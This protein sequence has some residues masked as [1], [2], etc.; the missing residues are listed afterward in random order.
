MKRHN[1]FTL[2]ELI[3]V[4]AI[5][6]I[7]VGIAIPRFM[8]ANMSARG[9]K[10]LADMNACESAINIYYIK[11]G[12]FPD[13]IGVLVS[14]FMVVWPKPPVGK[15]I[16][17]KHDNNELKLDVQAS[18]YVYA[19]PTTGELSIKVG[20]VTLGGMTIEEILSTS[21]SSLTLTDG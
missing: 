7:L 18:K 1:G 21:E 12:A 11:T 6:A 9:S 17:K 4:I 15:A 2:I 8:N 19:K 16:L 5:L 14:S 13:D 10:I 20:R 3:V